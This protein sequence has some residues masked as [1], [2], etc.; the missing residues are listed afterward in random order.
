M[1]NTLSSIFR[2][3]FLAFVQKAHIE[4]EG[5]PLDLSQEYIC[6]LV[7]HIEQMILGKTS[8]MIINLPGR[9]L[10]SFIASVCA[11]A[12]LLARDPTKKILIVSYS[13][14]LSSE[15]VRKVRQLLQSSWYQEMCRTR[16]S[17]VSRADLFT[18]KGGGQV[19]AAAINSVTGKGGDW[20]ILDDPHNVSDWN[21]DNAKAK[22]RQ[23]FGLLISRRNFGRKTQM[24]LIGHRVADDDLTAHVKEKGGFKHLRLPLY[25]PRRLERKYDGKTWVLEKGETLRPDAFGPLSIEMVREHH[26]GPSFWLYYQQGIGKSDEGFEINVEHFPV[27]DRREYKQLKGSPTVLSVDTTLKINSSSRNVVHVYAIKHGRYHLVEV[28]AA[29]CSFDE[30]ENAVRSLAQYYSASYILVEDTARGP[31]LIERL[32]SR[33]VRGSEV[34]PITPQGRKLKRL[35]ECAPSIRGGRV[36]VRSTAAIEDAIQEIVDFPDAAYDDN[37]DAMTNFLTWANNNNGL[38]SRM[39]LAP[40]RAPRAHAG[41]A[42]GSRPALPPSSSQPRPQGM[43][44]AHGYS[45]RGFGLSQ[46]AQERPVYEVTGPLKDLKRRRIR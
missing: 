40:T 41:I 34:I 25:A 31:L 29:K 4:L 16:I 38:I 14:D 10:K 11:P 8:N 46:P 3:D 12:F 24:L 13:F 27:L 39:S 26:Q 28:F 45:H 15:L 32:N 2:L 30:L 9:H 43:A 1:T 22:A 5:R 37:V 17:D 18:I 23:S 42:L 19:Q 21:N 36:M 6:Y 44:I 20:V 7:W 33:N 35:R